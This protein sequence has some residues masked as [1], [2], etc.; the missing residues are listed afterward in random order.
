MPDGLERVT[1]PYGARIPV[2]NPAI[3]MARGR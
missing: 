1:F 3:R 2:Y